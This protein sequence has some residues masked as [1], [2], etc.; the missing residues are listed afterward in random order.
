MSDQA[1]DVAIIG[2]G[3][4][5][6]AAA[7]HLAK[8]GHHVVL[9]EAQSYPHHKV[10]GEFLSPE[11]GLLLDDL[12][13]TPALQAIKPALIH[14]VSIIAP[15]GVTWTN[16]LPGSGIGISRYALDNLLAEQVRSCGVNV[17]TSTT[18]NDVQ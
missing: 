15:N 9:F 13:L 3:L 10:C 5:G 1:F 2:G 18:V 8:H 7:I 16:A 12:G 4:A 17:R 14:S 6:C 11:C